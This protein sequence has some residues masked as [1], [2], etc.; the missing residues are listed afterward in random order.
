MLEIGGS[1]TGIS[2]G[3]VAAVALLRIS[4]AVPLTRKFRI[5]HSL[6]VDYVLVNPTVRCRRDAFH[7]SP[8]DI[9]PRT[10]NFFAMAAPDTTQ[11]AMALAGTLRGGA[12]IHFFSAAE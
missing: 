11:A 3:N 8:T 5:I 7:Y 2:V 4:V 12:V 1:P 9:V 6:K 10:E